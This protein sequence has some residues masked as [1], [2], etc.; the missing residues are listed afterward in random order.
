MS[1]MNDSVVAQKLGLSCPKSTKFS[2]FI[3]AEIKRVPDEK[4]VTF[5]GNQKNGN[6]NG[7]I[8][9]LI[10][11]IARANRQRYTAQNVDAAGEE[12][13]ASAKRVEEARREQMLNNIAQLVKEIRAK[14][15]QQQKA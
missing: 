15:A 5:F 12:M 8:S 13:S 2:D 4:L 11:H 6:T 7:G 10:A 14:K 3:A 1:S 9:P